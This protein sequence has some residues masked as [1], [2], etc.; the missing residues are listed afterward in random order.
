MQPGEQLLELLGV[1]ARDFEQVPQGAAAIERSQRLD[2]LGIEP[3]DDHGVAGV[4]PD[5]DFRRAAFEHL[6]AWQQ[7]RV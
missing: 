1:L 3:A 5:L 2:D 4:E 6:E 7:L